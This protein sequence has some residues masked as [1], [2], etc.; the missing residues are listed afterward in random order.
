M[1]EKKLGAWAASSSNP[2]EVSN[3]IKGIVVALSGLIIFAAAQFFNVQLTAQDVVELGTQLSVL[4][5]LV[6]SLYGA[7]VALVRWMAVKF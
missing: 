4:G 6:F 7:G 5:G 3:R 1:N 2:E